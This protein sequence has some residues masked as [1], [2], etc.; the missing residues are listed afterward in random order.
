MR[1]GR[2]GA[3]TRSSSGA[4]VRVARQ[5]SALHDDGAPVGDGRGIRAALDRRDAH[6]AG[7]EERMPRAG[8]ELGAERAERDEPVECPVDR[9]DA[10]FGLRP[11][12]GEPLVLDAVPGEAAVRERHLEV[13]RLEHDRGVRAW[14]RVG[15]CRG[16]GVDRGQQF[17]HADGAELL[18]RGEGEH[19]VAGRVGCR[20]GGRHRRG[21][22]ARHVVRAAADDAIGVGMRTR[23]HPR[24]IRRRCRGARPA[25]A[26]GPRRSRAAAPAHSGA[27]DPR[28][29]AAPRSRDRRATRRS[30]PRARVR[31]LRPARATGWSRRSRRAGG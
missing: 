10:E 11:V 12:G 21:E 18:V 27:P 8:R 2:D 26:C 25:A 22:P 20:G 7:A 17:L 24:P 16:V 13:R 4:R 1:A 14:A 15:G 6:A 9:V 19:E 29:P 23:R 5:G 3:S 30:R 31:P 28:P